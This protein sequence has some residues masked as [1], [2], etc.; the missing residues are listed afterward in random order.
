MADFGY[1]SESL[2]VFLGGILLKDVDQLHNTT[3]REFRLLTEMLLNLG[4]RHTGNVG[5]IDE[6]GHLEYASIDFDQS[7]IP[8]SL[9]L[10]VQVAQ[11]SKI[12]DYRKCI[13]PV[14]ASVMEAFL[15]SLRNYDTFP[16]P[17]STSYINKQ[18]L[19]GAIEALLDVPIETIEE[20]IRSAAK[21]LQENGVNVNNAWIE[22]IICHVYLKQQVMESLLETIKNYPE[23]IIEV[24]PNSQE[25]YGAALLYTL[26]SLIEKAHKYFPS[27][28]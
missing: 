28:I 2:M 14:N 26:I 12:G 9:E 10:D 5:F 3:G 20:T 4:D 27:I 6:D 19:V 22:S 8:F 1:S 16:L 25:G 15:G 21:A 23:E 17:T 24:K 11:W 7:L 13:L 18:N